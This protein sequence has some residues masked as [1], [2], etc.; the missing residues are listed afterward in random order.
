V[1][2]VEELLS[3]ATG[4][5]A[6]NRLAAISALADAPRARALPVLLRTAKF[7]PVAA[8]RHAALDSLLAQGSRQRDADDPIQELLRELIYDG[9][10]EEVSDH[11]ARVLEQLDATPPS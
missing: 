4:D 6:D 2:D 10:D 7:S 8:D 5:F 3:A 9:D 11:A 1:V